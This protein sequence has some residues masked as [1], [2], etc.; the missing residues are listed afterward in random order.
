MFGAENPFV[1]G[2]K[3]SYQVPTAPG[4]TVSLAGRQDLLVELRARLSGDNGPWPRIAVLFGMGEA[5]RPA[6]LS[7]TRTKI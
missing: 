4:R 2:Q 6:W 1:D 5:G 3:R 7:N